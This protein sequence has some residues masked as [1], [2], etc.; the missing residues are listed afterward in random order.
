[1]PEQVICPAQAAN[2]RQNYL[3]RSS[4]QGQDRTV[5]LPLFRIKDDRPGP[6]TEVSSAAQRPPTRADRRPCMWMY[7]T[8]NETTRIGWPVVFMT[9]G[10]CAQDPAIWLEIVRPA[11]PVDL[12][13][14]ALTESWSNVTC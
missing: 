6:A 13:R 7:E 10:S 9:Y 12:D 5:D 11:V 8:R 3:I 4:G 14:A 1:M 2:R